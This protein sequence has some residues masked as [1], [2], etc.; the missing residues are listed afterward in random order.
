MGQI[1]DRIFG[2]ARRADV[3][4]GKVDRVSEK[5]ETL[6]H[7]KRK[8]TADSLYASEMSRVNQSARRQNQRWTARTSTPSSSSARVA[9]HPNQ[10]DY[11][12]LLA[13][14]RRGPRIEGGSL[15]VCGN[16]QGGRLVRGLMTRDDRLSGPQLNADIDACIRETKLHRDEVDRLQIRS[17]NVGQLARLGWP[18]IENNTAVNGLHRDQGLRIALHRFGTT[19]G[20]PERLVGKKI[21]DFD[22]STQQGRTDRAELQRVETRIVDQYNKVKSGFSSWMRRSGLSDNDAAIEDPETAQNYAYHHFRSNRVGIMPPRTA[23]PAPW[24]ADIGADD[25][26]NIPS[27]APDFGEAAGM[28]DFEDTGT[29]H[30]DGPAFEVPKPSAHHY[31]RAA[32]KPLGPLAFLSPAYAA[33]EGGKLIGTIA[34]KITTGK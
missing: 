20:L 22:R 5:I 33:T 27:V 1:F 4:Q 12:R 2:F 8:A 30:Q 10:K 18:E 26:Y 28:E 3:M 19:F 17:A 29:I 6:L 23:A 21:T 14:G 15:S 24:D 11:H 25:W 31:V 9:V 32:H 16:T 7:D 34:R 13:Q